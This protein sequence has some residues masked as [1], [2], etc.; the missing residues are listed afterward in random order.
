MVLVDGAAD[1]TTDDGR[2]GDD[3][4]DNEDGDAF[5][6]PPPRHRAARWVR[7]EDLLRGERGLGVAVVRRERDVCVG[8]GGACPPGCVLVQQVE[9][10]TILR[11]KKGFS[12]ARPPGSGGE[13]ACFSSRVAAGAAASSRSS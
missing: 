11:C 10:V 4:E 5:L 9:L 6:R 13:L 3:G 1:C 8:R 12:A 7:L 2:D